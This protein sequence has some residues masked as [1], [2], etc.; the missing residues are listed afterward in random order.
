MKKVTGNEPVAMG[1]FGTLGYIAAGVT[2]PA[3]GQGQSKSTEEMHFPQGLRFLRDPM[4]G[5]AVAMIFIYLLLSIVFLAPDLG[6]A[7]V[8]ER[9]ASGAG[10]GVAGH[11][12]ADRS[13]TRP[14]SSAAASRSSCSAF[15]PSSARSCPAFA[16]IAERVIPGA[17]PALDCPVSFPYAPNAVIIGFLASVVG[18]L[19]RLRHPVG[20]PRGGVRVA[21][22]PARDDPP[23]LHRRDGRR[24]RQRHRRAR[25][26]PSPAAS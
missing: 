5:T 12:L 15:G 24:L 13:S 11:R 4:V 21:A 26:G 10:G 18:G 16:G 3:L 1:H 23:L 20:R 17:V 19:R 25:A 9:S 8:V 6:E 14:W 7:T 22:H 2:G